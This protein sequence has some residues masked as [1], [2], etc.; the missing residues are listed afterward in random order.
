MNK[1]DA[2]R[3]AEALGWRTEPDAA[4]GISVVVPPEWWPGDAGLNDFGPIVE[5][6]RL[7]ITPVGD[8]GVGFNRWRIDGGGIRPSSAPTLAEAFASWLLAWAEHY[9]RKS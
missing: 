3:I 9:E 5:R 1:K 2:D 6:F 7:R 4:T 8:D